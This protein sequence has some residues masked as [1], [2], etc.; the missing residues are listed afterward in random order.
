MHR[1]ESSIKYSERRGG[2][3]LLLT[4]TENSQLEQYSISLESIN[5]CGIFSS[6]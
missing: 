3:H 4:C 1:N 2:S 6:N 5:Y